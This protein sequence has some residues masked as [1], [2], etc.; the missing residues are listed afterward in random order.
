VVEGL[1]DLGG[2]QYGVLG[3]RLLDIRVHPEVAYMREDE[4]R[5]RAIADEPAAETHDLGFA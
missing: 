4:T 1:A 5:R 3:R 2:D